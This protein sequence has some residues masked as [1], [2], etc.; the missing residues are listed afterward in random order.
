MKRALCVLGLALALLLAAFPAP[1]VWAAPLDQAFCE[2]TLN[3]TWSGGICTI[4]TGT[5]TLPAGDLLT[6]GAFNELAVSSGATLNVNGAL[7]LQTGTLSN[8]GTMNVGG[9]GSIVAYQQGSFGW[10]SVLQNDGLISNAGEHGVQEVPHMHVHV[11]AGRPLGR[12][13]QKA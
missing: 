8:Q 1:R 7:R 5:S 9:T 13:L 12:M 11:L 10:A 4:S 3:G 6:V 2:N